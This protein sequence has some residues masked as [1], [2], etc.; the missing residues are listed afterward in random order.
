MFF[1]TTRHVKRALSIGLTTIGLAATFSLAPTA[2]AAKV[3]PKDCKILVLGDSLSAGYG[4]SPEQGWV[5]L[6][7]KRLTEKF[8]NC[9]VFNA[10]ISGET[11]AGGKARLDELL[12]TQKPSHMVLELGANDGL[13]G[14]SLQVMQDNLRSMIVKARQNLVQTVLVGMKIPPNYGPNYTR[15]FDQTFPTLARKEKVPL[16]P[17]MLAGFADKPDAFQADGIHPNA[18]YQEKVLDN[19]WPVLSGTLTP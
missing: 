18:D 1:D 6:M 15:R 5:H 12:K 2:Y 16:V 11:T 14:L 9:S 4:L 17:F 19:I 3:T 7:E 13:R 10:S 8:P